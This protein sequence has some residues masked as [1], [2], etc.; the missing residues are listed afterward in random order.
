MISVFV[1]GLEGLEDVAGREERRILKIQEGLEENP[2]GG[3]SI[4]DRGMGEGLSR[5]KSPS[6]SKVV[7]K[8]VRE[9]MT[10]VG[11]EV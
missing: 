4:E 5:K 2:G 8:E 3:R 10:A 7:E 11:G 6:S 9:S 1:S